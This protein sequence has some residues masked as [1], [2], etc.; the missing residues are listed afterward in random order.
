M[1][2]VQYSGIELGTYIHTMTVGIVPLATFIDK[3]A[4]IVGGCNGNT[5][6][7]SEL[8]KNM[9]IDDV[10]EKLKGINCGTRGTSCPEQLARALEEIK[11]KS[12]A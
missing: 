8:V 6:G 7:I 5:K 2:A 9:K 1:T 10:I 4:V 12:L 11:E 3:L